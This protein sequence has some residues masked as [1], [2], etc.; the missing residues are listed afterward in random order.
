M[1]KIGLTGG[2][3]SGKSAVADTLAE[4]GASVIDTDILAREV[5]APGTAGLDEVAAAFGTQVLTPD[6]QLDRRALRDIVFANDDQRRQ[7]EAILHP[8]IRAA[9]LEA[10]ADASGSYVVF[11]V[12]LLIETNFV[13]LVDRVLVVDCDPATQIARVMARDNSSADDAARIIRS[14]LDRSSR[15]AAADDVLVNDGS[16]QELQSAAAVLHQEYLRLVPDEAP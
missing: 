8:R 4:L 13:E 2:I 11:V 5:V 1:L 12:P 6:G 14:Q 3:A 16:L 15:L 10:A 9:A 7:L